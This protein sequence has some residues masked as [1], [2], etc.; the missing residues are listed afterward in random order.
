[1]RAGFDVVDEQRTFD[2]GCARDVLRVERPRQVR[3]LDAASV[4]DRRRDAE[5]RAFDAGAV[6]REESSDQLLEREARVGWMD[7]EGDEVAVE[8]R[9]PRV[10]AAN[11]ADEDRHYCASVTLV[12]P[13]GRSGSNPLPRARA[14]A[15]SWP[16]TTDRSG[17]SSFT[18]GVGTG[19][20]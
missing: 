1:V 5:R 2:S 10:R 12:R 17:E 8:E 7:V 18:A 16:G 15:K 13:R 9:K 20:R 19:S 6:L 3:R 4:A 14:A 11:V